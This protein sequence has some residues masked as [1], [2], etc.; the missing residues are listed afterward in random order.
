MCENN[1]LYENLVGHINLP[2]NS[3]APKLCKSVAA[4]FPNT[5]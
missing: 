3:Y 4:C 5:T 2:K 1:F